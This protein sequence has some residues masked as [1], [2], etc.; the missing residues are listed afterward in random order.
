MVIASSW[1]P[2][3][4]PVVLSTIKG[5]GFSTRS[6]VV[7]WTSQA[8]SRNPLWLPG[9]T[10]GGRAGPAQWLGRPNLALVATRSSTPGGT[11]VRRG[12][13]NRRASVEPT[14]RD[15]AKIDGATGVKKCSRRHPLQL[16]VASS[17]S[18]RIVFTAV[19]FAVGY[20]PPAAAPSTRACCRPGLLVGSTRIARGG[21]PSALPFPIR[22][23]WLGMLFFAR[24]RR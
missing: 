15:A 8:P 2:W 13:L 12:D 9:G 23:P 17:P 6:K 21:R 14:R 5:R 7:N 4:A 1:C 22:V 18:L 3:A 19:D 11:P 10:R 16:P 20:L 24:R